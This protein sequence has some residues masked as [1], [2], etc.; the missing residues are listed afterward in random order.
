[1]L[2]AATVAAL[3]LFSMALVAAFAGPSPALDA[4]RPDFSQDAYARPGRLVRLPDGRRLNFRCAGA[5]SPTVLL[6]SGFAATSGAWSKV[7]PRVAETRRVCSYDRAGAG[8]SD[9]GPEPRDGAA[10]AEDLDEGLRAAH[11]RGPFVVVGHSAGALYVRL[12]ADLRPRDI[13]GMVLVDPSVEHQDRRL[14]AV[15]GP[16]AGSLDKARARAWSCMLAS[17]RAAPSAD[18]PALAACMPKPKPGR[19]ASLQKSMEDQ[20][21][22]PSTWRSEVSELDN[23]WTATSDEVDRGRR[24]YGAMPLI[25]LTAGDTYADAP[26]ADQAALNGLW[27]ALHHEIAERSSRGV[28]R[29][30]T[31]SS[32]LMMLDR[33]DAIVAAIDEVIAEASTPPRAPVTQQPGGR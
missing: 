4:A 16:G 24:S 30:V 31:R 18:D 22:L 19:A 15:F 1:M 13:V 33:P 2:G 8:F 26:N 20:A 10:I 28:E 3:A 7:Q 9:P 12:F 29:L 14:A 25:V 11:I 21:R 32:H 5:G 27:R 17:E 6:E 23:L